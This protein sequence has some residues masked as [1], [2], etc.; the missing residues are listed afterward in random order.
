MPACYD[1]TMSGREIYSSEQAT[2]ISPGRIGSLKNVLNA[3]RK[4]KTFCA[5]VLGKN[6]SVDCKNVVLCT[7]YYL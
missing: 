5:V 2:C 4:K 3:F 6:R 1:N 7:V